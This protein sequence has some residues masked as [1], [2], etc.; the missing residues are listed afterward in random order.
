MEGE[1]EHSA[2]EEDER[3]MDRALVLAK[4]GFG[5]VNPNP[6]VGAVITLDGQIVGEGW[7]AAFGVFTLKGSAFAL[8][9]QI[10]CGLNDLRNA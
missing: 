9:G 7:H 3:F 4:R 8:R 2:L 5:R 10:A 1:K 6:L